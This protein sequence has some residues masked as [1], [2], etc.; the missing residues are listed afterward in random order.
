MHQ[1]SVLLYDM[2]PQVKDRRKGCGWGR[3][4]KVKKGKCIEQTHLH[5]TR[6][7]EQKGYASEEGKR[8]VRSVK[9]GKCIEENHY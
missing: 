3:K 1:R 8:S 6:R 9:K 2:Y 7:G 5:L 4:G